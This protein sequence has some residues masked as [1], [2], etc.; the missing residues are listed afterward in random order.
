[1]QILL[2]VALLAIGL[3]AGVSFARRHAPAGPDP[4][5]LAAQLARLAD[6]QRRASDDAL[7]RLLDANKALLDRERVVTTTELDGKK[8][9]ID[10]QLGAMTNELDKVGELVRSLESERKHAYGRL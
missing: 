9:L 7:T 6:E 3:A 1:M 10:Q 4:A 2:G 8:S 5:E